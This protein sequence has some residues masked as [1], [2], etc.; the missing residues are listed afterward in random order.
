MFVILFVYITRLA[1]DL[2][3]VQ[4]D[5]CGRFIVCGSETVLK[6]SLWNNSLHLNFV[7]VGVV[8]EI[9]NGKR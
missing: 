3:K 2:F 7:S 6:G 9:V 8:T 4:Q 1:V 5:I